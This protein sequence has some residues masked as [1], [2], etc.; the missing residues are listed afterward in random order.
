FLIA[1]SFRKFI[2]QVSAAI[3]SF[4][5]AVCSFPAPEQASGHESPIFKNVDTGKTTFRQDF[6]QIRAFSLDNCDFSF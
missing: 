1:G 6:Y 2:F 3:C 5:A 4:S